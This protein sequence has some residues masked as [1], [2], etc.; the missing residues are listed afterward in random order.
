[1]YDYFVAGCGYAG[2]VIARKAADDGKKV[3]VI[4]R[5][6]TIGGNMYDEKN[7]V[8]IYVHKYGPHISVMNKEEVY[9][10]LGR[11]TEWIPYEHRV[12][13]EI[14][15]REVPLPFNL[16]SLEALFPEEKAAHLKQLLFAEYGEGENVPILELR[17]SENSEIRES[18][19]ESG[20]R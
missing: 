4:D 8:G 10:F 15:G 1:M 11:F 9:R 17:K 18:V 3:L 6:D 19:S 5:R 12:N 2:A 13:A 20:F 16:N 14:D 7:D